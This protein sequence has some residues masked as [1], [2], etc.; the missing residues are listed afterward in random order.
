MDSLHLHF[1]HTLGECMT[2]TNEDALVEGRLSLRIESTQGAYSLVDEVSLRVQRESIVL[3][4]QI[5][6]DVIECLPK[7]L[8]SLRDQE[9]NLT[10]K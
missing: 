9:L 5:H 7:E 3:S 8:G 4:L 2:S 10:W 1:Q 6:F